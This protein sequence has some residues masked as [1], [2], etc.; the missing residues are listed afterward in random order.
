MRRR[1]FIATAAGSA[2]AFALPSAALSAGADATLDALESGSGGRLGVFAFDVR[3]GR[4][5]AHRAD[6]R[7]P[8]CST[9]KLLL[10]SA[11]LESADGRKE[12][13]DRKIHYTEHDLLAYAPITTKNVARGYMTVGE[14]CAAAIEWSDNTAA[15]LLIA[16]LG[17]PSEV[18]EYARSLGDPITRLDRIEPALND[19]GPGDR[20]D[21]TSPESMAKDLHTLVLGN[22]L[23]LEN[24]GRLTGWLMASKTG[25]ERIRAGVPRHWAV[26]DKTGSGPNGTS[27]D[28]A[29]LFPP[30]RAPIVV[31]AYLTGAK[32]NSDRRDAILATVG[33]VVSASLPRL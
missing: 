33:K 17:G 15:N 2:A 31:A 18:T 28:I 13:L 9:F 22:A 30:N 3:T 10:V 20:R 23:S 14:L 7:F 29:V 27:N 12:K 4:A 26:G 21:T 5:I 19:V 1:D 11:V 16:S 24:R 8:M 6:Q 25:T 32:V